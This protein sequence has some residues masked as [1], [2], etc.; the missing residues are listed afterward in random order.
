VS[1]ANTAQDVVALARRL[2]SEN[3][4]RDNRMRAV[5]L[6][7]TGQAN[8]LYKG[9]FPSEWPQPIVANTIDVVAQDL[10]ESVG[11]LPTFTAAGDSILDE[12]KRSRADKLTKIINYYVWHSRLGTRLPQG[13]DRMMTYGFLPLR[14]EADYENQAPYIQLDDPY[15][16][17]FHRDRFGN[18][19]SYMRIFSRRASDLA[20]MFPEHAHRFEK[21]TLNQW[22]QKDNPYIEL[23]R[24]WDK[25]QE[26]LV[27]ADGDA[28]VLSQVEN[29]LGRIPVVI[30]GRPT[31][32]DSPRGAF[33]DVLWVYAAKAK[34][35]LL[36]LEATTKAVEAPIAL[37][38]DVQE[39]AFGPDAIL[40]SNTPERIRRVPM[41]LPQA[42]L[43]TEGKL[44]EELK[45]GSRFPEARA[46][47]TDS[48]V[49]T[50]RGVQALMGGF[51]SRIK[52]A[53]SMLGDALA[54]ALGICLEMDE[55]MWGNTSKEVSSVTN[56]TPYKLKY[57]P[58]KDI[59]GERAVTSEYGVMAGLDPN[60]ALVWGL[61]GLGAGLFSKSYLRRNLPVSMDVTEEERVIDVER[62]RDAALQAV[63]GYAQ[64]IP[65][66]AAEGGDPQQV[67]GAI[68]S[69]IDQRKKG[70]PIEAA[71]ESAFAP[72]EPGPEQGVV[73]GQEPGAAPQPGGGMGG[74]PSAP[75]SMQQMLA[76][77]AGNGQV[78]TSVRTLRQRS[79]A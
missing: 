25:E 36:S 29:R 15:G 6:V 68:Q 53:Q 34:L 43:I 27:M 66:M 22:G 57:T 47:Q 42:S 45:F 65:Q 71:L 26:R 72:P 5:Q 70:V 49:V 19:V 52:V 12:S 4:D 55:K 78:G 73:P 21:K 8:R 75:P 51:D 44:D 79:I 40:R 60:R 50:G 17:Y 67:I 9:I 77:L 48:S 46:G 76:S 14:V 35:A 10:S 3:V 61:Q 24:H 16:S 62:L 31:L 1:V 59:K 37:P 30:A 13:A 64:A 7:R 18:L 74:A 58:A 20:A 63:S 28:I 56:G 38:S 54:E 32:D 23:V 41:E 33:D 69:L 2:Q 39:M 11:T